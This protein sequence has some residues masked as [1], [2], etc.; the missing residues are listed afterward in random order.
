MKLHLK[1]PKGSIFGYS[2]IAIYSD[3]KVI[4]I[5]NTEQL[6]LV[7]EVLHKISLFVLRYF[8]V[9]DGNINHMKIVTLTDV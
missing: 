1:L 4:R 7:T 2:Y 8:L 9:H 3:N 5:K 6:P